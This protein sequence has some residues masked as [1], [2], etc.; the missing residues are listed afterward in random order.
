MENPENL[1]KANIEIIPNYA[2]KLRKDEISI[3]IMDFFHNRGDFQ[4]DF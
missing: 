1:T 4:T 3:R 2:Y